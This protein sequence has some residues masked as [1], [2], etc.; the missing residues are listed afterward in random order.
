MSSIDSVAV[1]YDSS[2]KEGTPYSAPLKR[3]T[4]TVERDNRAEEAKLSSGAKRSL[5]ATLLNE[6]ARKKHREEEVPH[7]EA[8]GTIAAIDIS[9]DDASDRTAVGKLALGVLASADPDLVNADP[10][11]FIFVFSPSKSGDRFLKSHKR[12][13][14][15][16]WT[17]VNSTHYILS[18]DV[19]NGELDTADS[20]EGLPLEVG[21]ETDA[22][23]TASSGNSEL[24]RYLAFPAEQKD[25]V[26]GPFEGMDFIPSSWSH[27]WPPKPNW[28][29]AHRSTKHGGTHALSDVSGAKDDDFV[30]RQNFHPKVREEF[31]IDLFHSMR[32]FDGRSKLKK[33]HSAGKQALFLSQA[34]N[35][36]VVNFNEDAAKCI[37][38]LRN[39]REKF[40]SHN[41]FGKLLAIHEDCI[42]LGVPC[43]VKSTLMGCRICVDD[44][45]QLTEENLR[46]YN[47]ITLPH[48]LQDRI[49]ELWKQESL[50]IDSRIAAPTREHRRGVP[51]QA[52]R[53][54]DLAGSPANERGKRAPSSLATIGRDV[55]VSSPRSSVGSPRSYA[56]EELVE[57]R[58]ARDSEVHPQ[59]DLLG[60]LKN[61]ERENEV[62]RLRVEL[63]EMIAKHERLEGRLSR[64]E[65]GHKLVLGILRE[66]GLL[67]RK[68]PASHRDDDTL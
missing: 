15:V 19:P 54:L 51:R 44:A 2:C 43:G 30:L 59:S 55:Q 66:H 67:K 53:Y 34:W 65:A 24:P 17:V 27:L 46:G 52:P 9:D 63:S 29:R 60:R 45:P 64:L 42:D 18:L 33:A 38:R 41:A 40:L 49:R 16:L 31:Y 58:S 14:R 48:G 56:T 62:L 23:V 8:S 36:F 12:V 3:I 57:E 26:T 37:A 61:T 32:F 7:G 35:A 68:R 11:G 39:N 50:G 5:S 4:V 1:D 13:C 21:S 6:P 47:G 22:Q 10:L 25:P 28:V 20:L